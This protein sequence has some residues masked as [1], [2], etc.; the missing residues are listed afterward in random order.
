[1]CVCVCVASSFLLRDDFP[2]TRR[3][4]PTRK[5]GGGGIIYRRPVGSNPSFQRKS[6]TKNLKLYD[7]IWSNYSDLTSNGGLVREI[8]LFQGN[9]GW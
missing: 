1:M 7:F 5:K 4:A 3:Y 6:A 8:P 2:M 9:L